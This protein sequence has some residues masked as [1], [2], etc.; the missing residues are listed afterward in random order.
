[1]SNVGTVRTPAELFTDGMNEN[2]LPVSFRYYADLAAQGS[3][4][5]TEIFID[6]FT[7][8][9]LYLPVGSAFFGQINLIARNLTDGADDD[10]FYRADFAFHNDAGT[11]EVAV[12]NLSGSNGNPIE[13]YDV[14]PGSEVIAVA[15][16]NTNDAIVVNFT[17]EASKAYKIAAVINGVFISDDTRFLNLPSQY[18]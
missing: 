4:A 13:T 7:D 10:C 1:M 6:G 11:V 16:D 12:A 15:A 14:V 9:R 5:A 3:P 2:Q 18:V 8:N 17:P